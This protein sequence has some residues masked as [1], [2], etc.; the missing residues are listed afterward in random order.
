MSK[1][2][3]ALALAAAMVAAPAFA[4][5]GLEGGSTAGYAV[6]GTGSF[7]AVT[8]S[9]I[10]YGLIDY[11]VEYSTNVGASVGDYFGVLSTV[12]GPTSL[13]YSFAAPTTTVDVLALRLTTVDA[14]GVQFDDTLSLELYDNFGATYFS[15]TYAASEF[16]SLTGT[17]YYPDS[18]WLNFSVGVGT[19]GFKITLS[20]VGDQNNDPKAFIDYYK[21]PTTAVPE[22]TGTAL[23]LAGLAVTG[24]V[25][26]RRRRA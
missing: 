13:S 16:F 10:A 15:K 24:L 25:A 18:G 4:D 3:S 1:I 14:D 21:T 20:N 5:V 11:G 17:A 22:P 12:G 9:P 19:T 26:G 2:L 23:L 8:T 6:S 7:A